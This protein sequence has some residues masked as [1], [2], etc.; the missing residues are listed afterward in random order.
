VQVSFLH[1]QRRD[2]ILECGELMNGLCSHFRTATV[3]VLQ[4]F[5]YI[6]GEI[7]VRARKNDFWSRIKLARLDIKMILCGS[8]LLIDSIRNFR[9]V[10]A[11]QPAVLAYII[12]DQL[13]Y[14]LL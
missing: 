9:L 12:A 11:F 1:I 10:I 4:V 5:A 6:A 7:V 3:E 14:P 13:H 2:F 8:I